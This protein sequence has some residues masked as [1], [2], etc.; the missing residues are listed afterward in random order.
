[1]E[2][3]KDRQKDRD[4]ERD[5]EK[6]GDRPN[7]S[8][9]CVSKNVSICDN[10]LYTYVYLFIKMYHLLLPFILFRNYSMVRKSYIDCKMLVNK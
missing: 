9:N 1:M 3:D 2:R 8:Q 4:R 7:L 5:R 6:D 10:L